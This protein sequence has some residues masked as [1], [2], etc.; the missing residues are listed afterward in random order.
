MTLGGA[1]TRSINGRWA[2]GNYPDN[3]CWSVWIAPWESAA[4]KFCGL[5]AP[6][7]YACSRFAPRGARLSTHPPQQENFTRTGTS[8]V[9][10]RST[11]TT[12]TQKQIWWCGRSWFR[13]TRIIFN[14]Q[15]HLHHYSWMHT[16]PSPMSGGFVWT[17]AHR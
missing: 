2:L 3:N 9:V 8:C 1:A 4:G 6:Y 12:S 15:R 7:G 5:H 10:K 16:S 17:V 11:R 14:R 13:Q